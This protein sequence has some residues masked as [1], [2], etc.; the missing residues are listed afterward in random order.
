MPT[1]V[2]L[3]MRR[4][5]AFSTM[6]VLD[7]A[8]FVVRLDGRNFSKLTKK[9]FIKP[10]DIGLQEMFAKTTTMLMEEFSCAYGYAISDEISLLFQK[11]FKVFDRQVEKIVSLTAAAASSQMSMLTGKRMQ[12]DSRVV[13]LPGDKNVLEYFRWRQD[14]GFRNALSDL[15]YWTL[16]KSGNGM[17]EAKAQTELNGQSFEKKITLLFSHN[18]DYF[19]MP[20]QFRRG[21]GFIWQNFQK[22][23]FNPQLN[24]SVTVDRRRIA[25]VYDLPA[26]TEYEQFITSQLTK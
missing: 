2:D 10:F 26:G 5:E 21:A 11:D 4:L 13:V 1:E 8:W 3:K 23:G 6:R 16:L 24:Q 20:S 19:K 22:E 25:S 7:D 9:E 14:D 17:T 18:V 12:F 15:C